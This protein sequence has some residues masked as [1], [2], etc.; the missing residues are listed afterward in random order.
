[1]YVIPIPIDFEAFLQNTREKKLLFHVNN[2]VNSFP[3]NRA[4]D[5]T[6]FLQFNL[7]VL[8]VTSGVFIL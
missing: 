4:S 3:Q 5:L 1:M 8:C 6:V 2:G 7:K